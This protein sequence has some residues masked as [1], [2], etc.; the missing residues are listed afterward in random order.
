MN[1]PH[2][3]IK[4]LMLSLNNQGPQK[5]EI[6][7]EFEKRY[8]SANHQPDEINKTFLNSFVVCVLDNA[9]MMSY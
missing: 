4:A 7:R 6:I 3:K 8:S 9:L 2:I 1:T 5:F